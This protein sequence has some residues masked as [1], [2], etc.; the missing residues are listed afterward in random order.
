MA[1]YVNH[2]LSLMERKPV[3]SVNKQQKTA[4][5]TSWQSA[6]GQENKQSNAK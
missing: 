1:L 6:K 4:S 2:I 3:V 5:K